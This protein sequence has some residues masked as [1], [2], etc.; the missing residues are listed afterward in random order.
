[1]HV[2]EAEAGDTLQVEILEIE[3]ADWGWTA[4]IP[5]FGLLAD[6]FPEPQLKIWAINK[7]EGF[8]WFDEEKGIRI[9]LRPFAG[10]M[11]VARGVN[12]KFSTIPPYNTGVSDRIFCTLTSACNAYRPLIC[13]EISIRSMLLLGQLCTCRLRLQAHYSLQE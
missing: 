11:G 2:A 5:G 8:A 7:R 9:L 12:G 6:E 10:E 1:M 3:T 4:L 13:R